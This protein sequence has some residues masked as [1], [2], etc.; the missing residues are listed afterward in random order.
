M[1]L[2]RSKVGEISRALPFG[3]TYDSME[4]GGWREEEGGGGRGFM[5]VCMPH[6]HVGPTKH[7]FPES[8]TYIGFLCLRV[9]L[10]MERKRERE[11]EIE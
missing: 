1:K 9:R 5:L 11:R 3:G 4:R 7:T 8:R 6:T 10:S 2:A